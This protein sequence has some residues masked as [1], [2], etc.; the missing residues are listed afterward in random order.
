M[1]ANRAAYISKFNK[2]KYKMYP[3]RVKKE[4]TELIK[5]LDSV[6]NRNSYII[7]LILE[8]IRPSVLSIKQIK[9]RVRPIMAKHNIDEAYLFGSY[10]RG[11]ANRSSDVDL[12][13][14]EG[15]VTTLWKLSAFCDELRNVLGKEVDIV[16]IGSEIDPRLLKQIEEDKIRIC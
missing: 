14:V 1:D 13:C 15:D 16:T 7:N 2:E 8:D 4:D 9:E 5:R 12:Y 3:F 6:P 11:E 10:S